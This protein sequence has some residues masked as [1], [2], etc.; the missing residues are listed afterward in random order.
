M[1]NNNSILNLTLR[2]AVITL[3]AGLILGLVYGVTKDPIDQQTLLRETQSRQ[4]VLP[5]AQEFEEMD[6]AAYSIDGTQY[7]EIG[8]LYKGMANGETVG[9][10]VAVV[11][12]GYSAGL[13]LTIGIDTEGTVTGVDIGSHEETPGLGANATKPEFLGQYEGTTGPLVVVKAATGAEEEITALTGATITSDAVTNSVNTVRS[14]F[15]ENLKE[16][17]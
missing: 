1:K 6:L 12:K 11:T 3:C 13:A 14:F 17:A 5:A 16:G 15:E 4:T 2:L 7:S 9:Y 10:T 8:Q